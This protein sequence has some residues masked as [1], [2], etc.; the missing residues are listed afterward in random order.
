ME[1]P[2]DGYTAWHTDFERRLSLH[3]RG[4]DVLARDLASRTPWRVEAH[5]AAGFAAPAPAA[6]RPPDVL[7][8]RGDEAPLCLEVELPETLVRRDTVTRLGRL[9]FC[10]GFD[11]RVI[12]I[13]DSEHHEQRIREAERL[14]ARAGLRLPV[15][16]L[17]PDEDT[18]TGADW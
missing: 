3:D 11:T 17:A 12:L 1:T 15:A 2:I 14:L 9:F 6:G 8:H 18:I 10:S 13:A 5:G 7:C 16:A 4:V